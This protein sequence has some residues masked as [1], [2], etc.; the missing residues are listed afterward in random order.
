MSQ[1]NPV[2]CHKTEFE[3][4]LCLQSGSLL[5]GIPLEVGRQTR[6]SLLVDHQHK[7]DHDSIVSLTL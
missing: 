3:T 2:I 7:L 1:I 5:D 4:Y 6:L